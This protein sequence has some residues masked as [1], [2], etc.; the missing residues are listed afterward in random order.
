[1]IGLEVA[2]TVERVGEEAQ[3]QG[4]KGGERV[5]ALVG[6]GG[7]A[8]FCAVPASMAMRIPDCLSFEKAAAIPEAFMTAYQALVWLAE[9]GDKK[10]VL[11]HAGASGVGIAAIQLVKQY[12]GTRVIVTAGSTEK[13]EFCQS[14]GADVAINYKEGPW[15]PRVK[16]ETGSKGVDITVDFIGGSYWAPN[17]DTLGMDGIVVLL[18]TLGGAPA[19][20]FDPALILRK[21]LQIK[22]S[23][24]RSRSIP[25]KAKLSHEMSQFV[26]PRIEQGTVKAVVDKVFDWREVAEAHKYM[27]GDKNKGKIVLKVTE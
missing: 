25:Y 14:L 4:W 16:E 20:A 21:R 3:K 6:G 26:F 24:L 19:E 1:V 27:E 9:L 17:L 18:A 7:Y 8:Q 22:G 15:A 5:C 23:S 2:G 12:K 10:T 13:L 11:I